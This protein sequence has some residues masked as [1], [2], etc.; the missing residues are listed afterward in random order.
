VILTVPAAGR[1]IGQSTRFDAASPGRMERSLIDSN[2]G[3]RSLHSLAQG[4][5]VKGLWPKFRTLPNPLLRSN[6]GA[7]NFREL[8]YKPQVSRHRLN[9]GL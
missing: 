6:F 8:V 9:S 3:R 7:S 2:P 1:I 4:W 5:L